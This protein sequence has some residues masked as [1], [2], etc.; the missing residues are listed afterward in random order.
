[1]SKVLSDL[2][3]GVALRETAGSMNRS[4]SRITLDSRVKGS[5][6]LFAA[7]SGTRSDGHDFIPQAIANGATVILCERLPETLQ[8]DLTY[9]RVED[10]REALGLIAANFYDNPSAKLKL[11]GVTGT[12]GKT[13]VVTLLHRLFRSLGYQAGMLSTVENRIGDRVLPSTHT[14][15]DSV[16]LQ[17]LLAEMVDQGCSHAFME[18]SSHAADQRRIAGVDFDVAVFTNMSHDHLDYH[19]DMKNYITAKKLFFDGLSDKA[20]AL[21]NIDDKRGPVMVQNTKAKVHTYGFRGVA[22]FNGKLLESGFT[23][24]QLQ[25]DGLEMH[26]L[27]IGEFNAYNLLAVYGAAILLDQQV[28]ETL[29]EMSRLRSAEGRFDYLLSNKDR[30]VGIVD[31][32]H[33]PDAL[34]KVLSTIRSIRSAD[35]K[36][37]TVVGCGGDRDRSKRPIMAKV[38]CQMSDKVV[39]TSDNPRSEM[40]SA[41]LDEMYTGV[42]L[43][44]QSRTLVQADRREA[45]RTACMLAGPGDII[46]VAGKGHEKYQEIEGVKYPFDDRAVLQ[47]TFQSLNR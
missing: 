44:F 42:E 26:S 36:V 9:V 7:L 41:I 22:D 3:Y 46:L 16:S 40:P 6:G 1:M 24:L 38:A 5:D 11:V 43:P 34:E 39:L 31:Y 25:F 29:R 30:L 12:N 20:H 2:L 17:A 33:T 27:L 10:S 13:S 21:V 32:A 15:P 37:I 18:V 19:G 35:E 45:I 14:T 8:D 28:T 4:I 23:G 47:E